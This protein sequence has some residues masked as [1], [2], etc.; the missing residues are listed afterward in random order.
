MLNCMKFCLFVLANASM[1]M[2][3]GEHGKADTYGHHLHS[4]ATLLGAAPLLVTK[5]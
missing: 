3:D 1:Q 5:N 2:G 4:L